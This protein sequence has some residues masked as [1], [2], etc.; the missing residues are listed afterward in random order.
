MERGEE[1]VADHRLEEDSLKGEKDD[2]EGVMT[3]L[4]SPS[5]SVADMVGCFSVAI[6]R[7]AR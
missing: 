2:R 6:V 1:V 7:S 3:A 4:L 5:R